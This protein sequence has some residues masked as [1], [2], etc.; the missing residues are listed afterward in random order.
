MAKI[1][2]PFAP[3]ASFSTPVG[4][5]ELTRATHAKFKSKRTRTNKKSHPQG[6]ALFVG[7]GSKI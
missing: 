6:V 5:C 3:K 7:R 2:T 4:V 1:P